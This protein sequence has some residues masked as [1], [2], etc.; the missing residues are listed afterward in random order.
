VDLTGI[1]PV[2]SSMPY[3]ELG[4]FNNLQDPGGCLS[5][6]KHKQH[7]EPTYRK[8]YRDW[9]TLGPCQPAIFR[10]RLFTPGEHLGCEIRRRQWPSAYQ[11]Q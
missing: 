4:F 7:P 5:P 10:A 9:D 11:R 3:P 2:T 8:A 6:C 1:E